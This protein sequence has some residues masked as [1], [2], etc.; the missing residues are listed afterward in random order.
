MTSG[1]GEP[2]ETF[3]EAVHDAVEPAEVV[4]TEQAEHGEEGVDTVE[5]L[6]RRRIAASLG[7]RRGMVEAGVPSV[8]FTVLW[9]V[10]KDL[11]VSLVAAG[12]VA[13]VALVVRLVQRSTTSYV[14]NAIFGIAIGWVFVRVA[15]HGGGDATEQALAYFLPGI[16]WTGVYTLVV[17]LACLAG[18]PIVGFMV[19]LATGDPNGWHEDRQIVRLCQ[20]I[21]WVFLAPGAIGVLGQGPVWVLG[22]T[23]AID[24]DTAVSIIATLRLG[25]GTAL[26]IAAA[27]TI[28]WLLAR[29]ATPIRPPGSAAVL[30][31]SE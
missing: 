26:R 16:L 29:N 30:R 13:V 19:G 9:L 12:A 14:M 31:G 23:G 5:A 6:V 3:R 24:G 11:T 1:H 22:H 8:I 28:I 17:G 4:E 20:R 7:G 27:A 18:W 10:T 2:H 25:L 21:T 15:A